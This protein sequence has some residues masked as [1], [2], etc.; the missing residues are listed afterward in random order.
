MSNV[1]DQFQF[2][3]MPRAKAG[4]PG[5][6]AVVAISA[7]AAVFDFATISEPIEDS[8]S[9]ETQQVAGA[10]GS[11]IRISAE[12]ADLYIISGTVKGD[13]TGGNVP[14]PAAVGTV[15]ANGVYTPAAKTCHRIVKDTY[16][17]FLLTP[18]RRALAGTTTAGVMDRFMGFV[19]SGAGKMRI[20][21]RSPQG[22]A[23]TSVP[24]GT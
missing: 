17:D 7:V 6:M 8:E 4:E 21:Q 13:V 12:G 3:S 16:Q 18:N 22:L 14:D 2:V 1:Q 23:A 11:Y 9:D 10:M 5:C 15:D 20:F 19:G 24:V